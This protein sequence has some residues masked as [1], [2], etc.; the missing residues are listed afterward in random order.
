MA[1]ER[2]I[3][4]P[5]HPIT[6][7]PSDTRVVVRLGDVVLADTTESVE[8]RE[9]GYPP[10]RYLPADA[11]DPALLRASDRTTWCPYKGE[12]SY[13]TVS[14]PGAEAVDAVWTY[15]TPFDAVA[16]IAGHLAFYP[17]KVDITVGE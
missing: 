5:D 4:G 1:R 6:V 9:A 10:V 14:V 7:V 16:P 11:V 17:D 15:R 3:P 12:A 2:R 13:F 8:L